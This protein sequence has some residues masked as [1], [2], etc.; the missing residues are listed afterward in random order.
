MITNLLSTKFKTASENS[1]CFKSIPSARSTD[2]SLMYHFPNADHFLF[3]K[4]YSYELAKLE[5][6]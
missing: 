4:I 2:F 1:F 3:K 5:T 6:S